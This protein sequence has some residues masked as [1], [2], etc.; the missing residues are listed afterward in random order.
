MLAR[1]FNDRT[2]LERIFLVN[3]IVI[4][5]MSGLGGA[6]LYHFNQAIVIGQQIEDHPLD[7]STAVLDIENRVTRL[8]EN[9]Q[10]AIETRSTEALEQYRQ[11]MRA[12]DPVVQAR[13]LLVERRYLGKSQTTRN[14]ILSYLN[15]MQMNDRILDA[16][17]NHK[18]RQSIE[19]LSR[20]S[21]EAKHVL[22][23]SIN[24]INAFAVNKART[25]IA[26][27]HKQR[28]AATRWTIFIIV[29]AASLA[30]VLSYLVGHT[31]ARPV[32]ALQRVMRE[33]AKG[34]LDVE[35][36]VL[37][38]NRFEAGAIAHAAAQ[39]RTNAKEKNALVRR[40]EEARKKADAANQAKSQ[41]LAMMNHELRTPM[42][43]ILGATQVIDSMELSSQVREHVDTLMAGGE[44]LMA[45]LNDV[46]DL[47]KIEAG[48][49]TAELTDFDFPGLMEQA[50]RMWVP[51]AEDK[52]LNLAVQIG[53]DVP[54]WINS[55]QTRLRQIIFNLLSNA[56]KFTE[57]GSVRVKVDC[58]GRSGDM[59][60]LRIVVRDTGIGIA[61]DKIEKLFKPFEQ[62]DGSITRRFGGTGLGLCISQKL[63]VL[64]GGTLK[65]SSVEG[66]G[67]AFT[68]QIPAR[69]AAA[70]EQDK[71]LPGSSGP[72][73]RA[74]RILVAEDND[75]NVKVLRA[76]LKA[77]P[78]ELV[79]AEN[80]QIAL[81]LLDSSVFDLVLMDIQM[82]VLDGCSAV[83]KLRA[84]DGPNRSVP[85]IAMTANAMVQDRERYLQA[86]M[87]DYISKPIDARMLYV[88]IARAASQGR[89]KA[90]ARQKDASARKNTA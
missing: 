76:L 28:R 43:A 9:L 37:H 84:G 16:I 23:E 24:K 73:T 49:L 63:A 61:A 27:L 47:S 8:S 86:G 75:L 41:F 60:Q 31:I 81:E 88:A 56:I 25:F 82:P 58:M 29:M 65:V 32:R 13:L 35:L 40:T 89:H 33:L 83:R 68:L 77:L 6:T 21:W 54:R 48:K 90:T 79:R 26:G 34:N 20:K 17:E 36:P 87:D 44:T 51:R 22:D 64:L 18:G 74:L 55:D 52:G 7:V 3:L 46:L 19:R 66:R 62:A 53:K 2:I 67:S 59:V 14:A 45:I 4:V 5:F 69:I 39:M 42:N 71:A 50:R 11:Y 80:G 1:W 78:Y 12:Q 10:K 72:C 85:V 38:S 57:Q 30:A 15:W 70:P